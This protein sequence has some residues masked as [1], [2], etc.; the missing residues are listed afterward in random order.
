M[1]SQEAMITRNNQHEYMKL[2]KQKIVFGI[3]LAGLLSCVIFVGIYSQAQTTTGTGTATSSVGTGVS[4]SNFYDPVTGLYYNPAT[5]LYTSTPTSGTGTT[6][7]TTGLPNTGAGGS[8]VL[9]T[10]MLFASVSA[11]LGGFAVLGKK[12]V[13]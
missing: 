2:I 12:F 13:R 6:G 3:A 10:I 1:P 9:N 8:A 5:E 4:S 7:G 11:L